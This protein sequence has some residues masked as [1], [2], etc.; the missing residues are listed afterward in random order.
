M[1]YGIA[2]LQWFNDLS[3]TEYNSVD[4]SEINNVGKQYLET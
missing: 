2:K 1:P 4:S 3:S